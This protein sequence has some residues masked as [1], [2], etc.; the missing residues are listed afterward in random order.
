MGVAAVGY[1]VAVSLGHVSE[2]KI[3]ATPACTGPRMRRTA[4]GAHVLTNLSHVR[5]LVQFVASLLKS[6]K[7]W[8]VL[9]GCLEKF[10][11]GMIPR[12]LRLTL[13]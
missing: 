5:E 2:M 8:K 12:I 7:Q 1:S 10:T 13:G 9:S 4:G 6:D 3:F 11:H